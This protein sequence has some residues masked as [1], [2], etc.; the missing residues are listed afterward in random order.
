MQQP[1]VPCRPHP[2][3]T[4]LTNSG[5]T[6]SD[7]T[8]TSYGSVINGGQG[9][10]PT[11]DTNALGRC[12]STSPPTRSP[13]VLSLLTG[14]LVSLCGVPGVRQHLAELVLSEQLVRLQVLKGTCASDRDAYG[15]GAD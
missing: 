4:A 15:G 1:D 8:A 13:G 11:T 2:T 9:L 14:R 12:R 5:T 10:T 6:F 3:A 7:R